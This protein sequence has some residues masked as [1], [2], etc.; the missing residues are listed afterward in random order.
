LPPKIY[1]NYCKIEGRAIEECPQLI[2]KWKAKG[3]QTNNVL[4]I[5]AEDREEQLTVDVI[6]R[7]GLKN[8]EDVVA[9]ENVPVVEIRKARGPNPPFNP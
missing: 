4:K 7:S 6:T 2:V 9:P 8:K 3:P 5:L 1:C